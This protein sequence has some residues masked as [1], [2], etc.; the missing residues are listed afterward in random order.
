M[1][2]TPHVISE[3][4][5]TVLAALHSTDAVDSPENAPVKDPYRKHIFWLEERDDAESLVV[6]IRA[7]ITVKGDCRAQVLH[8]SEPHLVGRIAATPAGYFQIETPDN[9]FTPRLRCRLVP[10]RARPLWLLGDNMLEYSSD[11]PIVI[12]A[13]KDI[14]LW[15]EVHE[16]PAVAHD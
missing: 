10:G 2:I 16:K 9:E 6:A 13:H 4:V 11:K 8:V 3:I 15:Y 5:T 7:N 14:D 12:H 1:D